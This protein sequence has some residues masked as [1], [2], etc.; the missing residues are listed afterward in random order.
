[1]GSIENMYEKQDHFKAVFRKA[2]EMCDTANSSE[3]DDE[4]IA[5]IA[6]GRINEISE[7][8]RSR[9]LDAIAAD[10]ELAMLLENLSDAEICSFSVVGQ[11]SSARKLAVA[12][13]AAACIMIGL[14]TWKTMDTA[15]VPGHYHNATPYSVQQDNPDYW[16]KLEQQRISSSQ[17]RSRYRDYALILSTSATFVLAAL[18]A[19]GFLRNARKNDSP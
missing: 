15:V 11:K 1:M 17:S 14:L 7:P 9:L 6:E 16:S 5:M 18:V 4:Y 2:F 13:A 19:A 10:P 8:E 3:L 12:W